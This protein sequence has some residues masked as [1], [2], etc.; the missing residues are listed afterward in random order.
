MYTRFYAFKVRIKNDGNYM[1]YIIINNKI[2]R[3]I[4]YMYTRFYAFEVRI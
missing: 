1:T 4:M 3:I 2:M